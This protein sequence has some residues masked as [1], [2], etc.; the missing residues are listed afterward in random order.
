MVRRVVPVAASR[1]GW[2]A[3]ALVAGVLCSASPARAQAP[4][5]QAAAAANPYVFSTDGALLLQFV[6]GDKT[7][8]YEMI[9]AKVKE[10]LMKS[11]KPERKQQAQ[12]WKLFKASGAGAGGT[13]IYVIT[14]DPAVKGADYSVS[15]I[16]AEGF[17]TEATALYKTYADLFGTPGGNLLPLTL[18][19]DFSK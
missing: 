13:A 11:D 14:I 8:D 12:G 19:S 17:P 15:A 4:A 1:F 2:M 5:A 6:K 18:V 3:V 10:A 9:M 16:L 7:A